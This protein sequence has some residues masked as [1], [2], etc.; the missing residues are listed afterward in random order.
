M[1]LI[2]QV[3]LPVSSGV[4]GSCHALDG[5]MYELLWIYGSTVCSGVVTVCSC[6]CVFSISETREGSCYIAVL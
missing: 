1:Q 3:L 2:I 4:S 5:G 6:L